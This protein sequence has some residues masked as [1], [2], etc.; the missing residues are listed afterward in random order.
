MQVGTF[1]KIFGTFQPFKGRRMGFLT[2]IVLEITR[3]F[4]NYLTKFRL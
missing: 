2:N 3:R 4:F 1:K